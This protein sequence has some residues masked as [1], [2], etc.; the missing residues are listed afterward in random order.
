MDDS[1]KELINKAISEENIKELRKYL[2]DLE[3]ILLDLN[4]HTESISNFLR[5]LLNQTKFLDMGGSLYLISIFGKIWGEIPKKQSDKYIEFFRLAYE[6]FDYLDF[7]FIKKLIYEEAI[8][9][10]T[11][12]LTDCIKAIELKVSTSKDFLEDYFNLIIELITKTSF[13]EIYESWHLLILLQNQWQS[14]SLTQKNRLFLHLENAYVKSKN[15]M[16]NFVLSELLG[17]YFSD[18]R[19]FQL[20]DRLSKIE[21]EESRA[22]IPHGLEHMIKNLGDNQLSNKA[23]KLLLKMKKD[24]SKQVQDEVMESLRNLEKIN[25]T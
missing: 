15:W 18:E 4:E 12:P 1:I 20:L 8:E 19:A 11:I 17:E 7:E 16:F 3:S 10:K 13:I 25:L 9:K 2:E 14:L 5:N 23:Y 6:Q 24:S 21:N 22:L